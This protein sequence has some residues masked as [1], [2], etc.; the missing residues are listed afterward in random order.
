MDTGTSFLLL[1]CLQTFVPE[2]ARPSDISELAAKQGYTLFETETALQQHL[3]DARSLRFQCTFPPKLCVRGGKC[4]FT[5]TFPE[6]EQHYWAKHPCFCG[7]SQSKPDYLCAAECYCSLLA[8]G[9][10]FGDEGYE[11]LDQITANFLKS[12]LPASPCPSAG[13]VRAV[14]KWL[15]SHKTQL[16]TRNSKQL[17]QQYKAE[18]LSQ[19]SSSASIDDGLATGGS[20]TSAAHTKGLKR[21]RGR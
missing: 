13:S 6:M 19:T 10:E 20:N 11:P 15:L 2:M 7:A 4:E 17:G 9:E 14:L 18:H 8:T 21:R 3:V 16:T 5:G 12:V 1:E